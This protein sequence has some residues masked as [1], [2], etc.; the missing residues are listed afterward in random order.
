M[1][2][3]GAGHRVLCPLC[4]D[5]FRAFG[6]TYHDFPSVVQHNDQFLTLVA[7]LVILRGSL[8]WRDT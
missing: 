8:F 6:G 7:S 2:G 5:Q 1:P 4:V 3:N